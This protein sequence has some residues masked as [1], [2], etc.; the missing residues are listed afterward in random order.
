MESM[1]ISLVGFMATGKSSIGFQLADE[2]NYN[3]YD[4]DE[5]IEEKA[6]LTI[7]EI[8]DTYGEKYFRNLEKEVLKEILN[9][10]NNMVLA[11]GGGIVLSETNRARLKE[12]TC[13]VL[14]FATAEEILRRVDIS[15]R[16]LLADAPEPLKK[17]NTMLK[18]REDAYNEFEIKIMTDKKTEKQVVEEIIK[19]TGAEKIDK[20]NMC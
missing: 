19:I 17:I 13:P 9:N 14:L 18:K 1:I 2:L 20:R 8:F 3:F 4:T 5:L 12:F 11:T 6:G 15:S 10:R 16:P 7:P